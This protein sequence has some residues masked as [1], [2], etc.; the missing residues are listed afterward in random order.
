[1]AR[2]DSRAVL[3]DGSEVSCSDTDLCPERRRSVGRSRVEVGPPA[4]G[5]GAD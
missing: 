4:V 2:S 3:L 5:L 1:M